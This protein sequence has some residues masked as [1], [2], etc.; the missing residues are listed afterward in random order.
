MAAQASKE[1]NLVNYIHIIQEIKCNTA[2]TAEVEFVH[3]NRLPNSK[4]NNLA[5]LVLSYPAGD[6]IW[7]VN[8]P[9]GVCIPQTFFI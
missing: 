4:P 7:F 2:G 6:Y 1:E 5:K 9:E 8:P 3:E